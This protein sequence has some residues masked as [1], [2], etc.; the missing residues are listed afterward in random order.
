MHHGSRYGTSN[1]GKEPLKGAK[2]DKT[3]ARQ[4]RPDHGRSK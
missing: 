2:H 3:Y 4:T 1:D